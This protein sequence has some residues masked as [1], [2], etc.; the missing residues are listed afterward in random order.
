MGIWEEGSMNKKR[1]FKLIAMAVSLVLM[2]SCFAGCKN[3]ASNDGEVPTIKVYIPGFNMANAQ[4]IIDEMNKLAGVNMELIESG[5]SQEAA[6]RAALIITTGE[7]VNWVNV[8]NSQPF[9]EWGEQ[10]FLN[11]LAPYLEK[12]KKEVPTLY[13]I[14]NDEL[15]KALKGDNGEIYAI[16]AVNYITN[17]GIRMNKEWVESTGVELPTTTEEMYEVLK[18]FKEKKCKTLDSSP[19][20]ADNLESFRWVFLAYGGNLHNEGYPRYYE[21]ANGKFNDYSTS[22]MN[23][24]ALKYL[25]KLYQEGLINSD[26][27][28]IG[29]TTQRKDRFLA[30][31]AGMWYSSSGIDVEMYESLGTTTLW[32]EA[33]EGPTGVKSFGGNAPMWRLNTIPAAI[34]DEKEILDTL[35]FIEWM[36]SQEARTLCSYGIEGRHYELNEKGE[37]DQSKYKDNMDADFA[38]VNGGANPFGWGW[39]SPF[40]GAVNAKKYD[41]VTEMI[42]NMERPAIVKQKPVDENYMAFVDNI[43]KY[44]NPYPYA[45]YYDDDLKAAAVGPLEKVANFYRDAITEKNF[46]IDAEWPAFVEEYNKAGADKCLE[47]FNGLIKKYGKVEVK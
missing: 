34:T 29:T 46:D 14:A 47:L 1:M 27:E 39:V 3:G 30:G 12:Y 43:N 41:T 25:R 45:A 28:V 37:I 13:K 35:K 32:P 11:D 18:V 38:R 4:C 24:E 10:G 21:D 9:K 22:D 31:K 15:F 44:I 17:Q 6:Q 42:A 23:K 40:A 7:D 5:G 33:P 36:H 20:I 26:W 8:G 19:I 16:P 2:L